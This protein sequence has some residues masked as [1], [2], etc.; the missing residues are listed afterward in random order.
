M[1]LPLQRLEQ[2]GM[3]PAEVTVLQR[4][5][6]LGSEVEKVSMRQFFAT[7]VEQDLAEWLEGQRAVNHFSIPP[8]A[9]PVTEDE[10]AMLDMFVYAW[11]PLSQKGAPEGVATLSSGG[12]ILESEL[13][14]SVVSSSAE[15]DASE[16]EGN[17]EPAIPTGRRLAGF[18][19]T[20]KGATVLKPPT[21]AAAGY[22]EVSVLIVE[23][24]A[25]KHTFS[26]SGINWIGAEP[27]WNTAATAVNIVRLFTINGG[28]TWYGEGVST[29]PTGATGATGPEAV[30]TNRLLL[31]TDVVTYKTPEE[32]AHEAR[33]ALAESISRIRANSSLLLTSGTPLVVAIEIPAKTICT[34]LGF[35][36]ETTEGTAADRTHLWVALLNA[37]FEPL[38]KSADY[39]SSTHTPL[40]SNAFIHALKFT[41]PYETGSKPELLYG[42]LCEVM[43]S[44]NPITIKTANTTSSSMAEQPPR[45][46]FLGETGRT[47]PASLAS[48]MVP[49]ATTAQMAYM[50]IV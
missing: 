16:V 22:N 3:E 1:E 5:Y 24:A 12:K 33:A 19:Y 21:G 8:T 23:N 45:T 14:E 47:T 50:A 15:E 27:V 28:T 49:S 38:R 2:I 40:A 4:L 37:S 25:G 6:S 44:T 29:G 48:P 36:V 18:L 26:T 31:P 35:M 32:E 42:V 34:G 39:T 20:I 7:K 30:G 46:C 43:S 13:P 10:Q 41:E 9:G 11:I 17:L